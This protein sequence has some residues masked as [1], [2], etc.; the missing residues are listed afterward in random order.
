[1][2]KRFKLNPFCKKIFP[3]QIEFL[4]RSYKILFSIELSLPSSKL[5]FHSFFLSPCHTVFGINHL[6]QHH[7]NKKKWFSNQ[8]YTSRNQRFPFFSYFRKLF[9]V[10]HQQL[11]YSTKFVFLWNLLLDS[12]FTTHLASILLV[13]LFLLV[14][15]MLFL[16]FLYIKSM[17]S[18]PYLISNI[19][20]QHFQCLYTKMRGAM[21]II[22]RIKQY[23]WMNFS[24]VLMVLSCHALVLC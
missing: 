22:F 8:I 5:I 20:L 2:L 15:L 18:V 13:L 21:T 3:S 24:H 10:S 23:F 1:M 16:V 19:Y 11:V 7:F 17:M 12:S 6:I 9:V 14:L 4:F